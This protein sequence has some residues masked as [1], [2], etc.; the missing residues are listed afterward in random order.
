MKGRDHS[1]SVVEV[2]AFLEALAAEIWDGTNSANVATPA[3]IYTALLSVRD[4]ADVMDALMKA[5]KTSNNRPDLCISF[6]DDN[7]DLSIELIRLKDSEEEIREELKIFDPPVRQPGQREVTAFHVG[8]I[9]IFHQPPFRYRSCLSSTHS[10]YDSDSAPSPRQPKHESNNNSYGYE[11]SYFVRAMR[12]QGD[13]LTLNMCCRLPKV[14]IP[15]R[16][17]KVSRKRNPSPFF[18]MSLQEVHVGR[19]PSS[20]IETKQCA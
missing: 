9:I 18:E 3:G 11:T 14:I 6:Y 5:K 8:F 1:T 13:N 15:G 4:T 7:D 12:Q 10:M 20:Q 2:V 19:F 17:M 16:R